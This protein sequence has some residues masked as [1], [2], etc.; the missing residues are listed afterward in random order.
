VQGDSALELHH[1]MFAVRLNG[2]D[3]AAFQSR[4]SLRAGVA[5]HLSADALPQ[6]GGGAPDRVAFR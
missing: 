2:L 4:N 1:E 6:R 5:D 3:P